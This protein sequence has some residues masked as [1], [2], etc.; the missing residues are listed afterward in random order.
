MEEDGEVGEELGVG[1][2]EGVEGGYGVVGDGVE[3]GVGYVWVKVVV[4]E[5]V[6]CVV[7]F[8]YD[9]CVGEE[10]EGVGEDG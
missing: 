6:Y 9:D 3:V 7:C 8:V 1:E 4:L 10:E 5:V 2:E